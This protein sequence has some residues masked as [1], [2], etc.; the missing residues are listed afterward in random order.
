M[1]LPLKDKILDAALINVAFDGWSDASFDYAIH[2][3]DVDRASALALFPRRGLDLAIAF[4][5]RGDDQMI[6]RMQTE[7]LASMRYR[8]RVAAAVRYRLEAVGPDKEAV[9]RGSTLFTLPQNASHGAKL[10]W[11]TAD[12]IWTQLGDSSTDYN[13]YT[14][15]ATL[16]AVYGSTVLFWLGDD[17]DGHVATW[18]FLDRRIDNVMDIEKI[19][20]QVNA[21]PMASKLMAGPSWLLSKLKAPATDMDP[22]LPGWMDRR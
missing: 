19:K 22:D 21:H 4:H 10:I 7:D 8:D 2:T 5:K 3:A 20:A 14:K 15:R 9:R 1:T 16:S 12:A 18:N 11:G 17:S 13:W 6:Q